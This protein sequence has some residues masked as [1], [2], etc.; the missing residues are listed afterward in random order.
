MK[1]TGKPV[2]DEETQFKVDLRT[3]RIPQD[4][5]IEDRERRSK[6]Q[7]LVDKLPTGC[8]TESIIKDLRK[9]GKFN[10]F[11]EASRGTMKELGNIELY[12]LGEISKTVQCQAC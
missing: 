4:A 9:T 1:S 11:S 8:Q 12:E 3:Q 10:G 6:I 7:E 2:A 5:V